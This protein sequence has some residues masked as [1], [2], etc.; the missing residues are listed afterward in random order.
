MKIYLLTKKVKKLIIKNGK[1][2]KKID[3]F[4]AHA[5]TTCYARGN[6]SFSV[7]KHLLSYIIKVSLAANFKK[8]V[9]V[10]SLKT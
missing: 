10:L 1:S 6:I 3:F 4:I 7:K 9:G 2:I 5:N 8:K